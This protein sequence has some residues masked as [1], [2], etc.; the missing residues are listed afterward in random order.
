MFSYTFR[1][2]RIADDAGMVGL[3]FAITL[4]ALFLLIA[5]AIQ[6]ATAANRRTVAQNAADSAALAGLIAYGSS[7]EAHETVKTQ[8]AVDAASRTFH[9][10]VD[11]QIANVVATATVTKAAS[12]TSMSVAFAFPAD[13][14]FASVFPT[15]KSISGRSISTVSKGGRFVDIYL[16]IDTSQSM[17]LGADLSD[18]Q[19]MMNHASIQ[20]SL[21]CHGP[22]S[23]PGTDTVEIAHAAGY[24]L[25][26]DVIRDA[27]KK[28]IAGAQ[29]AAAAGGP[30]VR[31]GLYTF[32]VDFHPLITPTSDYA[33]LNSMAD[34][35]DIA[36]W[37]SGTSSYHGLQSL[38]GA[39]GATGDGSSA[40]APQTYVMFMSDGTT[41]SADNASATNWTTA[42]TAYPPFDGTRCWTKD[43]PPDSG[44][45]YPPLGDPIPGACVPDPWTPTHGGNGVMQ[46]Q[47]INP[48][49]CQT[50]K[51]KNATLMTLY[52][53]YL[54]L[55]VASTD[56]G[57]WMTNE[58]R[59]TY[60]DN[61]II[62]KLKPNMQ[63]CASGSDSAFTGKDTAGIASAI[64]LM[65]KKALY[66]DVRLSQ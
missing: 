19:S 61:Y 5:G 36:R 64:D 48:L 4:P 21:A 11:H 53:E 20:C 12:A 28:V 8:Q 23:S 60:L 9:S 34:K 56:P 42:A 45:Y 43:P 62:P 46:I 37:H 38:A 40:A 18:Q 30:Q 14:A 47:A 29:A 31:I 63:A 55:P 44:P 17:G 15:L 13:F 25:R 52:T 35:I 32:D 51:A 66:S 7:A 59:F 57:N 49:W 33:T 2:G 1:R 6:Y 27:V 50:I 65:F 41:N 3:A 22:E 26:I 39:I 16:L 10:M 54:L 24:K 58:W